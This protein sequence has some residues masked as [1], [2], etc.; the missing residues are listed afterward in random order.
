MAKNLRTWK[1]HM[2]CPP[3]EKYR[4]YFSWEGPHTHTHEIFLENVKRQQIIESYYFETFW[5]EITK[6]PTTFRNSLVICAGS[7]LP[8][9]RILSKA[10]C[11]RVEEVQAVKIFQSASPW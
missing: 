10:G 3:A 7:R 5:Q 2:H 8:I 6:R 1:Q 4:F 11:F 9:R